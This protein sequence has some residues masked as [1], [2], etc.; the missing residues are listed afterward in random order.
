[1]GSVRVWGF[2]GLWV[3]LGFRGFRGLWVQLGFMALGV[4][5]FS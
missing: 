3:Q 5:G 2:R 4:Y 1:M